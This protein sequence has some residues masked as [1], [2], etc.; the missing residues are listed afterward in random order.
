M[1]TNEKTVGQILGSTGGGNLPPAAANLTVSDLR[2]LQSA[3]AQFDAS[4]TSDSLA[5]DCCCCCT[6]VS[7]T[8]PAA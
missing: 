6:A 5:A 7:S 2:T 4:R 3:F 8:L 1:A